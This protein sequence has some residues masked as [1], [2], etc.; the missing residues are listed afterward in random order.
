[1]Y[2]KSQFWGVYLDK[3]IHQ[4]LLECICHIGDVETK[5]MAYEKDDESKLLLFDAS[6]KA[7]L[8]RFEEIEALS[9]GFGTIIKV[10]NP[11]FRNPLN[12]RIP[13][14]LASSFSLAMTWT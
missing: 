1:M 4:G 14:P 2:I 3:A 7:L 9:N 13:T 8:E 10:Q 11:L 12:K 6:I 5:P